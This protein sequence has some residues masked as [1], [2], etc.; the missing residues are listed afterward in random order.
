M[1]AIATVMGISLLFALG[2]KDDDEYEY[3]YL[4]G[5]LRF[6]LD[7]YVAPYTTV[8]LEP[9][10]VSHPEGL[11][12]DIMY[13]WTVD[14]DSGSE[15]KDTTFTF[16]Y[17]FS[18]TLQL[19]SFTCTASASDY[20]SSST[21]MTTMTVLGGLDG[22]GSL[23]DSIGRAVVNLARLTQIVD[24]REDEEVTYYYTGFNGYDWFIRNLQYRGSDNSIGTPYWDLDVTN[25]VFGTFYSYAEAV[26]ACP[27]GWK[28]P[29]ADEWDECID[30]DSGSLM[31]NVYFGGR[32]MWEFWPTVTI[33]NNSLFTAIP[34]GEANL[35]AKS[36]S[37]MGERAVFWTATE[38]EGD[39]SKAVV[40]YLIDDQPAVYE[41]VVDK[42]SYGANVRCVRLGKSVIPF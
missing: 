14:A 34:A 18:D 27:E 12:D 26:E 42:V 3:N 40:K 10:G 13:V 41:A 4:D 37:G 28:L 11:D 19:Y 6:S 39:S 36:F 1:A 24:D 2:C 21:S 5:T 16:T 31:A 20:I 17:T 32:K 35:T 8:V 9:S 25:D 38:Y 22:N 33:S 29:T 7:A 30:F 15:V 23:T